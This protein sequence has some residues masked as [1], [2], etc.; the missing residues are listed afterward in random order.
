LGD[1]NYVASLYQQILGC[2]PEFPRLR[3]YPAIPPS[4]S[5][6][7]SD[8]VFDN[9]FTD[10]SVQKLETLGKICQNK[11]KNFHKWRESKKFENKI[12]SPKVFNQSFIMRRNLAPSQRKVGTGF[13][14]PSFLGNVA[15][16]KV[17]TTSTS[18]PMPFVA[19]VVST[20][21]HQQMTSSDSG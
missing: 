11:K 19:K 12:V 16:Q 2:G 21:N 18:I 5:N 13:V 10:V 15:I 14:A 4:T 20:T 3:D 17:T 8:K 7:F 6:Y 1:Q 9:W